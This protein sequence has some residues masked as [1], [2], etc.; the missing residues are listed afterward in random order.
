MFLVKNILIMMLLSVL[1]A[2]CQQEEKKVNEYY[3]NGN[4]KYSGN[5]INGLKVGVH[6]QYFENQNGV[7]QYE[8]NYDIIEGKEFIVSTK[9]Y[10]EERT[11]IFESRN[12]SKDLELTG[13]DTVYLKDTL[14]LKV[15]ITNP[16]YEFTD[17]RWGAYDAQ[18][19]VID[20][21]KIYYQRGTDHE[22]FIPVIGEVIGKKTVRGY[23]S[24]F[25]IK[26]V[27]DSIG[28]TLSEDTYFEYEYVVVEKASM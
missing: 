28:V 21:L 5:F 3:E 25:A 14:D 7:V 19:N 1:I 8:V 27:S 11:V 17:V 2:S 22:V 6:Y 16:K 26:P 12:V 20:S 23:I 24:D 13:P 18:L 4:I 10:N 15:R 9:K